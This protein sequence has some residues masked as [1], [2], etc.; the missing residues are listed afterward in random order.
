MSAGLSL[1]L[2]PPS[3]SPQKIAEEQQLRQDLQV[4]LLQSEQQLAQLKTTFS[5]GPSVE[6]TDVPGQSDITPSEGGE[7]RGGRGEREEGRGV[8]G[9]GA[10]ADRS[11]HFSAAVVERETCKVQI[12]KGHN[13]R[14]QGWKEVV[15]GHQGTPTSGGCHSSILTFPP[16]SLS[17]F[18][19]PL[20]SSPSLPPSLPPSPLSS[21]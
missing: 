12:P 5:N 4:K 13:P 16:L 9:G 7:G 1:T 8:G 6:F 21:W 14:K 17:L 11:C 20:S 3:P 15:S 19:L 2:P 10:D 18:P